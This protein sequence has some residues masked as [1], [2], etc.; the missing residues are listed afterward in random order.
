MSSLA[1]KSIAALAMIAVPAGLAV[2]LL[3]YTL[4]TTVSSVEQDVGDAAAAAR[5]VTEIRVLMERDY[6]LVARLP[7]ELDQAKV[8]GF[9][10]SLKSNEEKIDRAIAALGSHQRIVSGD[11]VNNIRAARTDIGKVTPQIVAATRSFSQTTALDLLNGPFEKSA[12]ATLSLLDVVTSKVDAVAAAA[13]QQLEQSS[14]W[15]K[16]LTPFALI[17]V[18]LACLLS[19]FLVRKSFVAPLKAVGVEMQAV[20]GDNLDTVIT[21]TARRDEIGDMARCLQLFKNALIAKRDAEVAS[22]H[23][24]RVK[25]QRA[26]RLSEITGEFE[27]NISSLTQGLASA[28]SELEGTARSMSTTA[29]RTGPYLTERTTVLHSR[30]SYLERPIWV[31]PV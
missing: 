21:S 7:A 30:S 26:Q 11:I 6:G 20:S 10:Q 16:V 2:G 1:T 31:E 29:E 14:R 4:I 24:G 19:F 13:R 5:Q 12:N 17:V 15:A 9:V 28:A 3:G 23:E 8:D 25:F 22:G 27:R 18:F